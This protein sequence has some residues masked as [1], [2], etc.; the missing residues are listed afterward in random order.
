MR[1][2]HC[3]CRQTP[4]KPRGA[5]QCASTTPPLVLLLLLGRLL[6]PFV[7]LRVLLAPPAHHQ[8]RPRLVLMWRCP[9]R[10]QRP[11]RAWPTLARWPPAAALPRRTP[12]CPGIPLNSTPA[13][14]CRCHGRVGGGKA[15]EEMSEG[16][17]DGKAGGVAM[18]RRDVSPESVGAQRRAAS[19]VARGSTERSW[20]LVRGACG[21][22]K[23]ESEERRRQARQ[24]YEGA[25]NH[26]GSGVTP[27]TR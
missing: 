20:N 13:P 9:M 24:T 18:P 1:P 15:S 6:S 14:V 12:G 16:V 8:P 7:L 25:P 10:F 27:R 4:S 23:V 3:L 17:S 21:G 5:R 26:S 11:R 2:C 19:T 22:E